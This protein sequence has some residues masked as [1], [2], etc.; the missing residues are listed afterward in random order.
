MASRHPASSQPAVGADGIEQSS[1]VYRIEHRRGDAAA[2]LGYT[3][4]SLAQH[5]LLVPLALQL[6]DTGATGA[7][8]LIEVASG[9]VLARRALYPDGDQGRPGAPGRW[10][11]EAPVRDAQAVDGS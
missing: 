7:L 6:V 4:D 1:A 11:R 2:V 10:G 3:D 9:D 8:V 5:N